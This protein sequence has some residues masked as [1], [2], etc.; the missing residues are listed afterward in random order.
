MAFNYFFYERQLSV[1]CWLSNNNI[2]HLVP[3]E[4]L[5]DKQQS[6]KKISISYQGNFILEFT[7]SEAYVSSIRKNSGHVCYN[8]DLTYQSDVL[9]WQNQNCIHT[10]AIFIQKKTFE[11]VVYFIL[12]N[13]LFLIA[14]TYS[15]ANGSLYRRQLGVIRLFHP[16]KKVNQVFFIIW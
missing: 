16:H 15:S 11:L 5:A 14:M 10:L 6:K 13:V 2:S 8:H 1:S 12:I 7:E 4:C 9:H 3:A